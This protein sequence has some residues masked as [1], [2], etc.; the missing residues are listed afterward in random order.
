MLYEVITVHQ[1]AYN[2][3]RKPFNAAELIANLDRCYEKIRLEGQLRQAQK[4]EAIGTVI[5]SYSIHYTKLYE[6]LSAKLLTKR[7]Q[8]KK[9][10]PLLLMRSGDGVGVNAT[11]VV[12]D[13]LILGGN[14]VMIFLGNIIYSLTIFLRE[15]QGSGPLQ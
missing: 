14:I 13:N 11:L 1:G 4:M 15:V 6:L 8:L 5:T 9:C 12:F 3:L 2:Y 10:I 7:Q